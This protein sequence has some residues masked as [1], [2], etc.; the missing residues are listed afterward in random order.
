MSLHFLGLFHHFRHVN[1]TYFVMDASRD[2][3][4]YKRIGQVK[5]FSIGS[6]GW[7]SHPFMSLLCFTLVFCVVSGTNVTPPHSTIR[8]GFPVPVST[9]SPEVRRAARFGVYRYNNSSNDLFLF[10]ESQIKKA[11]VQVRATSS[12]WFSKPSSNWPSCAIS[13][14]QHPWSFSGLLKL[15]PTA[16]LHRR[17]LCGWH[18]V[19]SCSTWFLAKVLASLSP[20]LTLKEETAFSR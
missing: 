16:L 11:M 18:T 10:K 4:Q 19:P 20:A 14:T 17:A 7:S 6:E 15:S 13:K 9:N 8:P 2:L 3:L 1:K 12:W 5:E